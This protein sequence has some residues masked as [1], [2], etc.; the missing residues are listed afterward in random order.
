MN[1]R[2]PAVNML[3]LVLLW[4]GVGRVGGSSKGLKTEFGE[5]EGGRFYNKVQSKDFPRVKHHQSFGTA[6]NER[7]RGKPSG[8]VVPGD[9]ESVQTPK[10]N[11]P[12]NT[13]SG[14]P[15]IVP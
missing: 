13:F 10:G 4:F 11:Q 12:E 14:N 7:K 15:Y 3:L 5:F 8:A 1:S 9:C 6:R 2:H